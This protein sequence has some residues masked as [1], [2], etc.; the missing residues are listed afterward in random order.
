MVKQGQTIGYIGQTGLATGCH[1][2]FR[3]WK[4]GKQVDPRRE[5]MPPPQAMDPSLIPGYM[6]YSKEIKAKLDEIIIKT[7]VKPVQTEAPS[8]SFSRS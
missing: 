3:F 8:F 5:K 6:E 4:N 1:V 7:P 2:C